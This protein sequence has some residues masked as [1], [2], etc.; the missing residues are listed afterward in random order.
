MVSEGPVDP[1]RAAEAA[2]LTRWSLRAEGDTVYTASSALTRVTTADG[3]PA[4]LKVA[5]SDEEERGGHLMVA[6]NGHG[7]ARV[8]DHAGPALLLERASGERDLVRI[9]TR[10]DAESTRIL[11]GVAAVLHAASDDVMLTDPGLDLVPLDRWFRAILEPGESSEHA[12]PTG[13]PDTLQ[14]EGAAIA[15]ELLADPRDVVVLHGDVHHGNVLDFGERGWL[16][17]DPKGLRGERAFDYCNLFCNP[18]GET[19]LIERFGPR[20]DVVTDVA[21]LD[22]DRL[23]RW[24][25]AWCALSARWFELAGD[26]ALAASVTALGEH[27]LGRL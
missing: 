1:G 21:G 23:T 9:S 7:A 25:A 18:V 12:A 2:W 14:R 17:I 19:A 20:L 27:A 26:R 22:R 10:S 16:A 11:C 8:L 3:A 4:M 6:W 5:V 15:R 13:V 24:I